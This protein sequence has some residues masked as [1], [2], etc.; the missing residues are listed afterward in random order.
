MKHQISIGVLLFCLFATLA[1]AATE[2]PEALLLR[3]TDDFA[4]DVMLKKEYSFGIRVDQEMYAVRAVPAAKDVPARVEFRKGNPAAPTFYFK[5]DRATLEMLDRG[6]LNGL[7]A[8]AKAFETDA[9]PMDADMMEGYKPDAA[10]L[11]DY[12]DLSYHF[13][14]RGNP[15][16]VN[17]GSGHTRFTHGADVTVFYY[18]PGLRTLWGS[19][20]KGM[21]AN[22][23]PKSQTNPFPSLMV[24]TRGKGMARIGGR[25]VEVKEGQAHGCPCRRHPRI[26]E[27][28]RRSARI[29]PG[30]VR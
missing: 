4:K 13:W 3:F 10:F 7:T 11:R 6:D 5:L 8:Q 27:P 21:H 29:D 19:L 18:Q 23:D 17:Y 25:E 26:L 14:T 9:A 28:Q 2:P 22:E 15:E 20:K 16:I 30:H 1:A 24:F 12:L